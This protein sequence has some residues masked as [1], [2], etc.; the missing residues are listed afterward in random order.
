MVDVTHHGHH[1]RPLD[2]V[3]LVALVGAEVDVERLQQLAVLVLRGHDLDVVVQLGGEQLQRLL[4]DRLGRGHHLAEVEQHLHQR[5]R[6]DA[7]L[8]GEVRQR[9]TAGKPH[10]LAVTVLDAD[11]ADGRRLH[12]VELL[13]LRPLRLAATAGRTTRTPEGTLCAAT[14][15]V[16]RTRTATAATGRAARAATATRTEAAT[17]TAAATWTRAGTRSTRTAAG[18]ATATA[19]ATPATAAAGTGRTAGERTGRGLRHHRRVGPRRTGHTRR[20]RPVVAAAAVTAGLRRTRRHTGRARALTGAAL[21]PGTRASATALHAL[22][23][24]E[25]V[26]ARTRGTRTAA[27]A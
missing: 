25:R 11:A 14:T 5:R 1:R 3:V 15:A 22:G 4:V 21:A 9:R 17:A 24:A 26:V 6:V 8:L 10:D 16:A 23:R 13:A 12:V 19:A 20:T 27:T 7:D 2:Q 18:T